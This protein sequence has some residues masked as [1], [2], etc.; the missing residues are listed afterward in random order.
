MLKH[1]PQIDGGHILSG[2][3]LKMIKTTIIILVMTTVKQW[4]FIWESS[5]LKMIVHLCIEQ[6]KD[7]KHSSVSR[8]HKVLV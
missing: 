1:V 2:D 5:I 7:R 6:I 4:S 8:P 3:F